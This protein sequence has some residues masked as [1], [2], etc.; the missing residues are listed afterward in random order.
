MQTRNN[1]SSD[2]DE[3]SSKEYY[4]MTEDASR[5]PGGED[6]TKAAR[7]AESDDANEETNLGTVDQQDDDW[8]ENKVSTS[9]DDE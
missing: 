4:D 9:L 7:N 6:A 8:T 1:P 3:K 5:R 2:R